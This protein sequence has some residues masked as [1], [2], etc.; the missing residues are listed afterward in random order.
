MVGPEAARASLMR[1]AV[2]PGDGFLD[3]SVSIGQTLEQF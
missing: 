1:Q 3:V 2:N